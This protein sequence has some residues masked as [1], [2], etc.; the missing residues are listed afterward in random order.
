MQSNGTA[1]W[2]AS[3]QDH[4]ITKDQLLEQ[5]KFL[6]DNGTA[7]WTASTRDHSITEDQLLEQ[8]KFLVD[9]IYIQVGNKQTIGIPMETDC[10]IYGKLFSLLLQVQIHERKTKTKQPDSQNF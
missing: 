4:S 3:T 7:Y 9:N 1:Y 5:I 2:T 6:V 8:I 10:S